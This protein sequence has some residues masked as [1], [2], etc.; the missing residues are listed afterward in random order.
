V[1]ALFRD[2][3]VPVVDADS[4]A[5]EVVAPGSAVLQQIAERFG[6]DVLMPDGTLDRTLLRRR[7]FADA[8][9]RAELEALL[10]PLIRTRLLAAISTVKAPYCIVCVPL[11][12]E[13]GWDTL[14]DRLVVVDV[15][16]AVQ[17]DRTMARDGL[18]AA[19][20]EAIMRTQASRQQR[21]A[22][23]DDI[24]SNDRDIQHLRTQVE[25]LHRLYSKLAACSRPT[26]RERS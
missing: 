6:D 8:A 18:T 17:R 11:L 5:R 1:C 15:A 20:V 26:V 21:L 10:H 12:V 22:R 7:V 13:S 19:D 4:I 2:L 14:V 16:E 23:A 9:R 25:T 24:I 3:G